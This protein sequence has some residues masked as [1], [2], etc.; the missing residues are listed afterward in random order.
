MMQVSPQQELLDQVAVL[1]SALDS[2][3]GHYARVSR[4]I[5][6]T[7]DAVVITN[8]QALIEYVNPAFEVITGY[9]TAEVLGRNPGLLK[10]GLHD[11]EFY[12]AMWR[13][14]RAGETFRAT[15]VN[16]KKSGELF[17]AEQTITPVKDS[18]DRITDFVSVMKD[19]TEERQRREQEFYLGLAR[20]VQQRFHQSAEPAPGFD[21]AGS[22]QA[23]A[24]TG[25]DYFDVLP[26][27]DGRLTIAIGDV[28]GHGFGAALLMAETR[29]Y[30]RAYASLGSDPG[31]L[32]ERLNRALAK[33]LNGAQYVTLL[34]V[35]LDSG[36][37]TL[38]YASA[39][40][41]TGYLL[42]RA[43]EVTLGLQSTGPPLGLFSAPVFAVSDEIGYEEGDT[44]VLLTDGITEAAGQD[45]EEFGAEGA[46]GVVRAHLGR[47]AREIADAIC[48]AARAFCA[49]PA[50]DDLTAVVCRPGGVAG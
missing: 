28:S 20:E 42:D 32:L 40:H 21:V 37:R 6:Q 43:G 48:A 19:V 41:V 50:S 39:G 29:A 12:A 27:P 23:A 34:V 26:H 3:A 8:D 46:L 13:T 31:V 35:R 18:G 24:L 47:P 38:Q 9:P 36:R 49:G 5:E 11:K 7:A 4:A 17:W 1:K 45:G 15:I 25:G 22:T 10:S 30:A 2:L 33:D 44:L 16:R 14:L